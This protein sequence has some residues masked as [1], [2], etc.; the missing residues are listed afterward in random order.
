M[1]YLGL[2]S[3]QGD[4][5]SLLEQA[6]ILIAE[7]VG[8]IVACSSFLETEPWGFH[9]EHLFLNA[10][11][12]VSSDL[13]PW[14]VLKATQKIE[15]KLGRKKKSAGGHYQ[16]RPIDIDILLYNDLVI[17]EK[18]LNIPH[19]RLLERQFVVKPLLEIAPGI[20]HPEHKKKIAEL[21]LS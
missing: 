20:V 18:K 1:I 4:R 10:V 16:D 9:S 3:N 5:R 17:H 19:P 15:Q 7:D 12:A 11:V 13:S 21:I 8:P 2:G 14:A 6:I